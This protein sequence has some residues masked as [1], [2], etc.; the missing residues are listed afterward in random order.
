MRKRQSGGGQIGA[1][2]ASPFLRCARKSRASWTGRS[3]CPVFTPSISSG[4]GLATGSLSGWSANSASRPGARQPPAP[5]LSG[6]SRRTMNGLLWTRK[7]G[8]RPL[9]SPQPAAGEFAEGSCPCASQDG[10][11]Q[12]LPL[13]PNGCLPPQ[14]QLQGARQGK[15]ERSSAEHRAARAFQPNLRSCNRVIFEMF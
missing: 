1:M 2:G 8:G 3:P 12:R 6:K 11:P 7:I 15:P 13:R 5:C 9:T 10:K 4:W 14:V